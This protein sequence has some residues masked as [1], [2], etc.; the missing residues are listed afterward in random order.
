MIIN[1][2]SNWFKTVVFGTV[3]GL[4][5]CTVPQPRPG[6]T[7][8]LSAP[9]VEAQH[10]YHFSGRAASLSQSERSAINRFL[11]QSALRK[12]DVVIVTIPTSGMAKTDA[13]RRSTMAAV[14]ALVP[15]TVRVGMDQSFATHSTTPQ[16][17]GLIRVARPEG[18]RV[19]CQPGVEDLGCANA[20]NLAIMIHNPGDVLAPA[21]TARTAQR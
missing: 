19:E 15:A 14:L 11:D 18:I 12:G 9:Y 4:S 3:I 2:L 6:V 7:D 20:T 16:Q 1:S 10:Q 13:A 8:R 5:A 17:S 21:L